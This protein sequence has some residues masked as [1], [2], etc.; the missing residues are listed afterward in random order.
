MKRAWLSWRVLQN[1]AMQVDLLESVQVLIERGGAVFVAIVLM[2]IFMW[3]LI[4]ERYWYLYRVHPAKMEH[5]VSLWQ[6]RDDRSSWWARHVRAGLIADLSLALRDN[7]LLIRSLTAILPLLGLLGTV[8]GMVV[9]FDVM[10]TFGT[11][12]VRGFAGGISQALLTTTAGLV[13]SI[14]GLYFSSHLQYRVT[15]EAQR[16]ANLLTFHGGES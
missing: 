8:T 14:S 9:I 15:I 2:S 5:T 12:N 6:Q 3:A 16:A 13:T 1:N 4:I 10:A 11:G 7:L